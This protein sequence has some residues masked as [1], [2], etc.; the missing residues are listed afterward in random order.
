MVERPHYLQHFKAN[1]APYWSMY[2]VGNYTFAHARV[3]WREQ[4]SS[5]QC[6]V[7]EGDSEPPVVADAKL[8]VVAC[9]SSEEAHY[10]AAVLNSSPARFVIDSYVV[11]VQISTHVLKNVAV[12][13]FSGRNALHVS[14]ADHSRFCHMAA[15]QGKVAKLA[16]FEQKV[17]VL[18][19]ELWNIDDNGLAQIQACVSSPTND[20][21]DTEE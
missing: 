2:N 15:R 4:T 7:I 1:G 8:I 11:K 14:L 9:S 5:F 10:L 21:P 12:P 3:V 18:A 17:D 13:T 19:A 6:A 20:D 16:S